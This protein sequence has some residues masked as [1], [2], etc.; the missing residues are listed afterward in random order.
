MLV[1]SASQAENLPPDSALRLSL[2]PMDPAGMVALVIAPFAP[3][4]I[5]R[6]LAALPAGRLVMA[7]GADDLAGLSLAPVILD[8]DPLALLSLAVR[9]TPLD[10]GVVARAFTQLL[11]APHR[12]RPWGQQLRRAYDTSCPACG[13]ITEALAYR[14]QGSPPALVSRDL[15]CEHCGFSGESAAEADDRLQAAGVEAGKSLYWEMMGRVAEASDPLRP[16]LEQAMSFYTP[17]A[18]WGIWQSLRILQEL[19]LSQEDRRALQLILAEAMWRGS[20]LEGQP[21]LLWQ[22]NL[23]RPRRFVERNLWRVLDAA[24]RLVAGLAGMAPSPTPPQL[25]QRWPD[26]ARQRLEPGSA[27]LALAP[28]PPSLP[29]YWLLRFVWS[30]WLFGRQ[31]LAPM[32]DLLSLRPGEWELLAMRLASAHRALWGWLTEGGELAVQWRWRGDEDPSLAILASL[33]AA[34]ATF[35]VAEAGPNDIIALAVVRKTA[36]PPPAVIATDPLASGA[37]AMLEAVTQRGEPLTGPR[38]RPL[39]A[40]AWRRQGDLPDTAEADLEILLDPLAPPAGLHVIGKDGETWEPGDVAWWWLHRPPAAWQPASDRA[41]RSALAMLDAGAVAA[42]DDLAWGISGRLPA[43]GAP[44]RP[45][46]EALALSYAERSAE[47]LLLLPQDR[48]QKRQAELAA[49]AQDLLAAGRRMGFEAAIWPEDGLW[50]VEWQRAGRRRA[51]FVL[52]AT[53]ALTPRVWQ[54]RAPLPGLSRFLVLPGSRAGLVQWRIDHQPLWAAAALAG[55]WTF[56]KFRHLREM[57]A[58]AD[59][60]PERWL[61][62][63]RLDPITSGQA[64]QMSLF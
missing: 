41:E 62:H 56:T 49:L 7:M 14:W 31:A 12:G 13:R 43:D 39:V 54:S 61:A 57:L 30:G 53:T 33:P 26:D 59:E 64:E 50:Q 27:A 45:W 28:V 29:L 17:R 19:R 8:P 15:D 63:L 52:T 46:I 22:T 38:L 2:P 32:N 35:A 6:S 16:R 60:E 48:P 37:A 5:A 34:P 18:L 20:S 55:G 10:S 58:D 47:G 42:T 24:A 1:M 23:R 36:A 3:P 11:D 4:L 25:S 21:D 44:D 51:S 40:A 9:H